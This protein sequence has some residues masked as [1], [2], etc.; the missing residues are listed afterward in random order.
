MIQRGDQKGTMCSALV[1]G[2]YLLPVMTCWAG[3]APER[4]KSY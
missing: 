1:K 4:E 2:I 3:G